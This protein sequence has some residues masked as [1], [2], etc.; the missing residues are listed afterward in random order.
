M[1]TRSLLIESLEISEASADSLLEAMENSGIKIKEKPNYR[2]VKDPEEI[3]EIARN[4]G[5]NEYQKEK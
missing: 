3:L 2:V 5:Y 1:S 4:F